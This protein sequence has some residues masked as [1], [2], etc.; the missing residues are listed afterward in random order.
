MIHRNIAEG[1]VIAATIKLEQ[2]PA[3]MIRELRLRAD[4]DEEEHNASDCECGNRL[5][6]NG[7]IPTNTDVG[8]D[9]DDEADK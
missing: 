9:R 4:T 1:F 6:A 8:S 7:E 3:S 2:R 5:S